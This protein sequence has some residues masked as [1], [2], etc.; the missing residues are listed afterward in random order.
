MALDGLLNLLHNYLG[1]C[2][3]C[4]DAEFWSARTRRPELPPSPPTGHRLLHPRP[5]ALR[6]MQELLLPSPEPSAASSIDGG[7][8]ERQLQRA[9]SSSS[10][11]GC[12]HPASKG[13]LPRSCP[14]S[15]LHA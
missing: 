15:P 3:Y 5:Q 1:V 11:G 4:L 7:S 13:G 8:D 14:H 6:D 10:E 9:A 12:A 2:C